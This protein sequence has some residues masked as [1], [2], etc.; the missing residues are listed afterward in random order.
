MSKRIE[1]TFDEVQQDK[2]LPQRVVL[3]LDVSLSMKL[4]DV[5][6]NVTKKLDTKFHVDAAIGNS[7]V[8]YVRQNHPD[9][10]Q[11]NVNLTDPSGKPCQRCRKLTNEKDIV[12]TIPSP[13]MVGTWTVQVTSATS[14]PVMVNIQVESEPRARDEEP[15]R[16]SCSMT[17]LVVDR[18]DK[19][20]LYAKVTKGKKV[21]LDAVV[22]AIVYR[23]GKDPHAIKF[24]LYDDGLVP[25]MEKDDGVYSGYFTAFKGKGR[26]TFTAVVSNQKSTRLGSATSGSDAFLSMAFLDSTT[27][28]ATETDFKYE[29][30]LSMLEIIDDINDTT[31]TAGETVD[32][33]QR[34]VSAGSFQVAKH[35]LE[36]DV[37]PGHIRDLAVKDVRLGKDG[38]LLV[39][40]TWT[41]PGAHLMSGKEGLRCCADALAVEG[42]AAES[43]RGIPYLV[44][45]GVQVVEKGADLVGNVADAANGVKDALD[46]D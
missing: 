5:D 25:D 10:L 46:E 22:L 38:R 36:A 14:T 37:P 31:T 35:I 43:E 1:M 16:V 33:F 18:A 34:V 8:V 41:W 3:V 26:Y 24:Q 30:P 32:D 44:K 7:T 15:L 42:T 11:I 28:A 13:A 23:P 40:L 6:G 4:L 17:M 20:V 19:M 45:T 9:D 21:V 2:D 39:Q 29:Y 12:I 27:G